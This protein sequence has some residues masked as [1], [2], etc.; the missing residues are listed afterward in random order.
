[1]EKIQDQI[2]SMEDRFE[3][4]ENKFDSMEKNTNGRFDSMEN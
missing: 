4:V 1:M 2:I 3:S